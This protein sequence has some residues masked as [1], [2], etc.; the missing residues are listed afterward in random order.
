MTLGS[1]AILGA[2]APER[3]GEAGA[4]QETSF[5]LGAGLGLAVLGTVLS[6][7]YRSQFGPVP[8]ASAQ[9]WNTAR[10]SLG[11]ATEVAARAG[12]RVGDALRGAAE[13]AFDTGFA[14]A[15]ASAAVVLAL[16]GV[17]A[18]KGLPESGRGGHN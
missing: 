3:A 1:D 9:Q 13:R 10:G 18:W 8:G 2:A 4:V 12:G 15:T 14:V 11:A 5:S 16:L 17:L 7:V 6:L